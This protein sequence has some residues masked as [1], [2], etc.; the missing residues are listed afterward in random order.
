[1]Y[2]LLADTVAA[3][4]LAAVALML[5]GGVLALRRPS[6][7]WAHVPVAL[8]VLGVNRAGA[9]CPLTDLELALRERAGEAVYG[10]GFIGHYLVEPIH[11]GGITPSVQVVIYAL[12][13]LPNAVAYPLLARRALRRCGPRPVDRVGAA[14]AADQPMA[15]RGLAAGSSHRSSWT[16]ADSGTDTQPCVAPEPLTWRKIAA[17]R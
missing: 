8:A 9:D 3:L 14:A 5:T 2:G 12:A 13:V 7:L 6:L 17:P 4:H 10:G 16:M 1:V 11:P 15:I